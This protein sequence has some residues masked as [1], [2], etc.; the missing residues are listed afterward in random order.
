MR[1]TTSALAVLA[2]LGTL[3]AL[4]GTLVA[5]PSAHAVPP[6][7][8]ERFTTLLRD[9][10]R[11]YRSW[12]RVDDELRW[13]PWLC[14]MPLASAARQSATEPGTPH[15]QKLFFVY[16][17]DRNAYLRTTTTRARAALGQVVVKES[18]HPLE[19]ATQD[20]TVHPDAPSGPG[21]HGAA[22]SAF[23][24]RPL[25][26]DGH[27]FGTGTFAGLYVLAK[28]G[29]R[30]TD[31]GW[32]YGTLAPDGTITAQGQVASCMGCHDDAP[33]DRLFGLSHD[34]VPEHPIPL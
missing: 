34:A 16:A 18:F 10:Y 22:G 25:E 19:V 1:R 27:R 26:R 29:G 9:K 4:P 32:Q 2:L 28:T 23:P 11:D 24:Y 6:T 20:P 30:G 31:H 33:H 5:L 14:R 8:A 21:E 15:G 12:G 7:A 17:R 3:V 13:A